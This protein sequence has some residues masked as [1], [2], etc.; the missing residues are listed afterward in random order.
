M[1]KKHLIIVVGPTA[2][3]KTALG[4]ELAKAFDTEIISCDSRQFFKEMKI[5]TAKPSPEELKEAKHH[6]IDSHSI[7]DHYS[8]GDFERDCLKTLDSIYK[9]NNVAVMVGGSGL[10][11]KAICEGLDDFPTID[12][13]IRETLN[14]SFAANGIEY[15]QEKLKELDPIYYERVDKKN[16]QRMIRALEV[17]I[18]TNTPYSSY[19]KKTSIERPFTIQ[20]IGLNQDRETLYNRINLRVDLMIENGLLEDAKALYPQKN[21][22]ALQTVGYQEFFSHFDGITSLEE[23][24]ELVKRNS[25]RYAKKQLTWFNRDTDIDWFSPKDYSSILKQVTDKINN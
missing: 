25:R 20:K 4:I 8:V 24:I 15:L 12:P 6:F 10:Y 1:T 19:T 3:G 23:A 14:Q 13:N 16:S 9:H 5:G 11:V 2:V 18:G 21:I 22:N 17:S 7:L